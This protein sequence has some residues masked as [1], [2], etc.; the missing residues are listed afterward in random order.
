MYDEMQRKEQLAYIVGLVRYSDLKDL[1][2][3]KAVE[4][5]KNRGIEANIH[6]GEKNNSF[7]DKKKF[8][9]WTM[10]QIVDSYE[11]KSVLGLDSLIAFSLILLFDNDME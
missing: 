7:K 10:G 11:K 8:A 4:F 6:V 5:A 9:E 2:F 3:E 1:S